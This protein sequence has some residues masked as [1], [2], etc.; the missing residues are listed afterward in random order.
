MALGGALGGAARD[1]GHMSDRMEVVDGQVDVEIEKNTGMIGWPTSVVDGDVGEEV[2]RDIEMGRGLD[3]D[4]G[5]TSVG[6]WDWGNPQPPRDMFVRSPRAFSETIPSPPA[7]VTNP[8][9]V[10]LIAGGVVARNPRFLR[11]RSL[12]IGGYEDG[13]AGLQEEGSGRAR[14]PGFIRVYT[15]TAS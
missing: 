15:A 11:R 7:P 4:D 14:N 5:D 10:S 12:S 2:D 9:T 13:E 8:E 3:L 6:Y 1:V